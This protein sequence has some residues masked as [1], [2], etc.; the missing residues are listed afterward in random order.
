MVS[1]SLTPNEQNR[2]TITGTRD[3]E[4]IINIQILSGDLKVGVHDFEKVDL[5]KTNPKGTKNIHI[6]IPPKDLVPVEKELGTTHMS[7]FG[8]SNFIH[9]HLTI[10]SQDL[11]KP[12]SYSITYSSGEAVVYLQDGLITEYN[13]VAKKETKFIYRNPS[14]TPIY[15]FTSSTDAESLKKLKLEYFAL[16][17]LED[18]ETAT[19]ITPEKAD[20]QKK[21]ANPTHF[22]ML[23]GKSAYVFKITN[24]NEKNSI[25]TIGV[26][27][28][29]IIYLPFDHEFPIE[30]APKE[31]IY[32]VLNTA[33]GGYAKV[34]FSKCGIS[35][36]F[37][38]YT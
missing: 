1:D 4:I 17:N 6:T 19:V 26:N 30:L 36:P 5:T 27:N 16:D 31:Y 2:Y 3:E 21:T 9:L 11:S 37:I 18:E 29:E 25:F 7:S 10:E 15:L 20:F 22:A 34:T 33:V 13:L 8:L 32:L 35:Y 28:R 23:P 24:Q 38:G 14:S 12:A